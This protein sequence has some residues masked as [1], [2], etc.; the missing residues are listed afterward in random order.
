MQFAQHTSATT[1]DIFGGSGPKSIAASER[2]L[3]CIVQDGSI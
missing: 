1:L 3:K 2:W